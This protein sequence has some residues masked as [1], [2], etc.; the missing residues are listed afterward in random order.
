[1]RSRSIPAPGKTPSPAN[2]GDA[3]KL[4]L[5]SPPVDGRANQ[6]CIEFFAKLLMVPRSSVTIASGQTSRQKVIRVK[7]L[8]VGDL[9]RKMGFVGK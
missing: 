6:A 3:L 8:S 2:S 7:G 9:R 1:M 4:S 5:T